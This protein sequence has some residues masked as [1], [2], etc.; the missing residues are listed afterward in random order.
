MNQAPSMLRPALISGV[1]FGIAGAIPV[2]N[3]LNCACCALIVGCGFL[4]AYLYSKDCRA[5]GV[6]FA[7]GNGAT[8][9]LFS[10]LIYGVISGVLG[11]LI[12]AVF[13]MSDWQEV[14]QQFQASGANVDPEVIEQVS[15]F[16][17]GSGSVVMLL[18]GLFLALVFGAIFGTIGGLI[19]GS[20]FKVQ[21][22]PVVGYDE[23]PPP[24]PPV[25]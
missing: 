4:A 23:T 13:G 20:V 19:G 2:I 11:G 10:G 8:V 24:P 16:M 15:S 12:N 18:I 21:V 7:A 22:Q 3:W 5:A 14:I 17:E 9:G 25:G 1:V 6:P